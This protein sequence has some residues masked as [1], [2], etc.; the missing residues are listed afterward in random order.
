[1]DLLHSTSFGSIAC[2]GGKKTIG[3]GSALLPQ[4]MIFS[5]PGKLGNVK[6]QGS[7]V[8]VTSESIGHSTA[9]LFT[10]TSTFSRRVFV[11]L[12][13]GA[14]KKECGLPNFYCV[15]SAS[16]TAGTD[17]LEL[18]EKLEPHVAFYGIQAPPALMPDTEFGKCIDSIAAY[19]ADALNDFQPAGRLHIGGYCIGAV[20]ALAM[21]NKLLKRGREVGPLVAI[22]GVPENT[23]FAI[24]CW[25]RRYWAEFAH[26]AFLRARH[27]Q[28]VR[29]R[30]IHSLAM[31]IRNNL[32]GIAK[33]VLGM[34]R[35]QR[36]GGGY[37]IESIFDVSRYSAVH[38][39][40]INRLLSAIFEYTPTEYF[41]EV[42]VYE[43]AIRP[44]L[45]PP[46]VG[47]IWR[48]LAPQAE[49]VSIIGTHHYIMREPYVD[50][51]ARD[52]LKRMRREAQKLDP[53]FLLSRNSEL[54][55]E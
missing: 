44:P 12:N 1:M 33:N 30:S 47:R 34:N 29:S 37:S 8:T 54:E 26:N 51:L 9:A 55:P 48:N 24:T 23:P 4:T 38:I 41:G 32:S 13:I 5:R 45:F 49:V 7:L 11:P 2:V 31:S 43:A 52:L 53:P 3:T 10:G 35:A 20:I 17:F 46:Q 15:H 14:T 50:A 36:F 21:V 39:S 42:V 40:F 27:P 16:G 18:A 22:D 19:Y 6:D 28:L 25:R